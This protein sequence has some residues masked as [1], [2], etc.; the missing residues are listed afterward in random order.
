MRVLA[1][2]R[3]GATSMRYCVMNPVCC[4]E[5]AKRRGSRAAAQPHRAMSAPGAW[6]SALWRATALSPKNWAHLQAFGALKQARADAESA[7]A[8]VQSQGCLSGRGGYALSLPPC[9]QGQVDL[10]HRGSSRYAM[11][12]MRP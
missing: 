9:R 6:R 3:L 11:V 8:H 4:L 7:L 5:R 2:L 12:P 10:T 1:R